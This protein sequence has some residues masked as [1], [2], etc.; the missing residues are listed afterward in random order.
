MKKKHVYKTAIDVVMTV[1]LLL[2]MAR[3]I[4]G[5]SAHEWLGVGMMILWMIHHIMN[6]SWYRHLLKGKYTPV[7]ILQTVTDFAIFLSMLG[8]MVS[9]IILS[10]EVFAFLPISGGIALARSLHI[11]SAFW[12]YIA[13][14]GLFVFLAYYAVRGLQRLRH[15]FISDKTEQ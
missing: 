7:R 15:P 11:L 14:M 10:R 6:R 2:L 8:L 5:D 12:G 13:V 3:Q 4:T 9:G 1:L